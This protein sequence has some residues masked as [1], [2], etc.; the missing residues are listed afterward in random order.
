M[1]LI[2]QEQQ[3]YSD[4][5]SLVND[6]TVEPTRNDTVYIESNKIVYQREP[7]SVLPDDWAMILEQTAFPS[8]RWIAISSAWQC[9]EI[10]NVDFVPTAE[11]TVFTL[12]E[13]PD[14]VESTIF[15]INQQFL[16]YWASKDFIVSWTAVTYTG[17]YNIELWDDIQIK[18]WKECGSLVGWTWGWI[19]SIT[20]NI[21]NNTDT[22]NPVVTQIQSDWNQNNN[23]LPDFIKN[24]PT[25][26]GVDASWTQSW[27]V[28]LTDQRL[29]AWEKTVDELYVDNWLSK[30]WIRTNIVQ[31]ISTTQWLSTVFTTWIVWSHGLV[32]NKN[33][34]EMFVTSFD[35]WKIYKT[36]TLWVSTELSTWYS[37]PHQVA[38]NSLW[39]LFVS[40]TEPWIVYKVNSLWVKTSFSTWLSKPMWLVFDS[41]DNLYVACYSWSEIKKITPSWAVTTYTTSSIS[42]PHWLAFDSQWNLFVSNYTWNTIFK[43]DQSWVV[44][45]F[46]TWLNQPHWLYFDSLDMLFVVNRW[47]STVRKID[48]S[49]TMTTFIS[50]WLNTPIFLTTD[51]SN[52]I[53][54]TNYWANNVVKISQVISSTK[55]FIPNSNWE[56]VPA[57]LTLAGGSTLTLL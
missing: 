15:A 39:E 40:D 6:T 32:V 53:Y 47:D 22:F 27:I 56:L 52:N 46:K 8:G 7:G 5:L 49:W 57:L 42:T 20:G 29:W 35:Q 30:T 36:T 16:Q 9:I 1:V 44:S 28:N 38:I 4:I 43:V 2:R 48:Q 17:S 54:I 41:N 51:Q 19:T 21:V 3:D 37:T 33:T 23:T 55:I 13:T 34:W 25:I 50:S 18:Y 24:K 10:K 14:F 11:Q 31:D 12:P 26:N 45:T